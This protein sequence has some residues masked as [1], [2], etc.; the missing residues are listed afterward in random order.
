[1]LA[2]HTKF[3]KLR[4]ISNYGNSLKIKKQRNIKK[5]FRLLLSDKHMNGKFLQFELAMTEF[6][7]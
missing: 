6:S 4:Q 2:L 5:T 7:G 1:M 3:L